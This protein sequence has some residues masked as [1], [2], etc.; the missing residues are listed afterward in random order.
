MLPG[1]V[2]A[3]GDFVRIAARRKWTILL[4][5]ATIAIAT[6][7]VAHYLP[8]RYRS[9]TV[10]LVV[11]Q[12]VPE[13]YVKS[14]V[15]TRIEDRLQS[16]SQQILSRTRLERIIV[17][18][19]LYAGERQAGI[20]EDVV[21]RMRTRDIRV[22]TLKGDAFRVAFI[23]DNPQTVMR[24]TDRLASLFIDENLRDREILAQGTSQF[25]GVQLDE[26]RRRLVEQEKKLQ[27]Y[28]QRHAGELPSQAAGNLQQVQ[29]V[30][31][32][33]QALVESLNRDVDRKLII[34]RALAD[35]K[36]FEMQV[37]ASAAGSADL[38]E[39]PVS[40]QL[41]VEEKRLGELQLRLTAEHPDVVRLK[42]RING[43]KQRAE[44]EALASP[45]SPESSAPTTPAEIRQRNHERA[46]QIE[47]ESL[48]RQI[49]AKKAEEKRLRT[50]AA[51]YQA[52]IE[53][54][55]AR[56]TELA[57]LTR[58]YDTLRK[59]YADLLGKNEESKIAANLER[60]QIGEQFK[61]LDPARPAER[62]FSP[63]RTL[64]N[65]GGV[66]SGL[67]A[68]IML[69]VFLEY[70]DASFRTR[71]DVTTALGLPVL[72]QIPVIVTPIE[73]RQMRRR[74]IMMAAATVFVCAAV[75]AAL[76]RIGV[77]SGLIRLM[78]AYV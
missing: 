16:I 1:K 70:R 76:W 11:P 74:K 23:G 69:A 27:D 21:E 17:D 39:Q 63:N 45:L 42:R 3:P 37:A 64:I 44:A 60:R 61:I 24:V 29:N 43:L 59:L 52:R 77:F 49:A 75:T 35:A 66:F 67:A 10:I 78:H 48:D 7:V 6:V 51:G 58:D 26:A 68:G 14:T 55:P 31:L 4:P 20:M 32:Q 9:E 73:I 38:S 8:N 47:L 65:L 33:I 62:P 53:A 36:T 41:A 13:S 30:Q 34:E 25:L 18:F 50:V 40:V 22:E 28:R 71:D 5:L 15:T 57:E 12:Q 19:N 54:V 72:A 56:E 2:L 46:L